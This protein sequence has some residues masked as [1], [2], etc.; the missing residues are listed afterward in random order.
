MG[1]IT[2]TVSG[3]LELELKGWLSCACCLGD[4]KKGAKNGC[5]DATVSRSPYSRM[6]CWVGEKAVLGQH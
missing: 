6:A 5:V 1:Y 2:T 3:S 4:L